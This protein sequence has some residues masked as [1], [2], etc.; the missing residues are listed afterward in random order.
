MLGLATEHGAHQLE[1]FVL[2]GAR[3]RP[4]P[5]RDGRLRL[6]LTVDDERASFESR[7]GRARVDGALRYQFNRGG[8]RLALSGFSGTAR[9]PQL[10][11]VIDPAQLVYAG[12]VPVGL[13][14]GY[15]PVLA[16]HYAVID[17]LGLELQLTTG[18]WLWKLEAIER[19]GQGQ[20][21]HAADA[22]FEV[23][24]VGV[25]GT[26]LDVGWLAEYLHDSRGAAATTPFEHDLLLGARLACNDAAGSE[27]L[28]SVIVDEESGEQL[29][30]LEGSRR[31]GEHD[32]LALEV[33]VFAH[34]PPPQEA[35]AF[36]ATP[37]TTHR[38]RPLADD[39]YL[40]LAWTRFF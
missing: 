23:T 27:L 29:W 3:P 1:G 10:R 7:R 9:E 33:R 2:F 40:R 13:Q 36:L 39:D 25:A 24:Q 21:F 28:A 17:Q 35:F 14:S 34:T 37:D 31:L 19:H 5:G 18:D 8:L 11:P 6:P 16:P 26:R 20:R 32:R 38:L 4:Y 12:P 30:S 15:R 22:G